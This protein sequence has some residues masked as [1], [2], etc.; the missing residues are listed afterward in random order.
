MSNQINVPS[1]RPRSIHADQAILQATLDLLAEVGYQSMSI[2]A[3][4]SRAGVGKTTIYRRYNSK[5]ELVADAIESFRD[6]LA[7]PDTGSFWGDM[8]I[9]INN[10]AKKID[11][12]LGRQTLALIISTASSNPQFAEVYWTKYTKVRR[13]AL[14]KVLKRAKS[15]SEIHKDADIE[16]VIDL[17]S[18]SLY[19][20][21]I[22][23]P[24]TEP[25]EAYMRRTMNLL[26]KGIGA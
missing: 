1:G 16:L 3:I 20:A 9:L 5:E 15:R 26:L 4:A 10:A 18:G 19:Y 14:S 11:S 21:L 23:K 22:F 12:P 8:D 7:I 13:E 25:V 24:I 17:L 6:D 2:E